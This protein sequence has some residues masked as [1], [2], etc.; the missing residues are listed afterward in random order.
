MLSFPPPPQHLLHFLRASEQGHHSSNLELVMA[1]Q[2][3]LVRW[4]VGLGA[5][6]EY[7]SNAQIGIWFLWSSEFWCLIVVEPQELKCMHCDH[8]RLEAFDS[9]LHI[10]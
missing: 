9:V 1:N 3:S 5:F 7:Y 10:N 6:S 8:L 2:V 4:Q